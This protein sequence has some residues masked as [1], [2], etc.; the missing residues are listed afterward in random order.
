MRFIQNV[1]KDHLIY[2]GDW[3]FNNGRERFRRQDYPRAARV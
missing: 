1:N 2:Q 3:L